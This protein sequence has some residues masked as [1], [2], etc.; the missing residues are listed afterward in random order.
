MYK[1]QDLK[2]G[3]NIK[4]KFVFKRN[5]VLKFAETVDDKAP[6]HI[7]L[8]YAKKKGLKKNIVH[9]FYISSIFSGINDITSLIDSSSFKHGIDIKRFIIFFLAYT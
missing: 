8:G 5:L 9:G 3:Q 6:I 1:F 2:I 7:D 4:K